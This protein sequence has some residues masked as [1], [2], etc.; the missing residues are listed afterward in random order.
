MEQLGFRTLLGYMLPEA[1]GE[2]AGEVDVLAS[3]DGHLFIF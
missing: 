3:R 1:D 2:P